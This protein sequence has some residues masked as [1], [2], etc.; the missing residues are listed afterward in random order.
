MAEVTL[1]LPTT[2]TGMRGANTFECLIPAENDELL[3]LESNGLWRPMRISKDPKASTRPVTYAFAQSD[4]K[5]CGLLQDILGNEILYTI[6][7]VVAISFMVQTVAFIFL[8]C[9]SEYVKY[10]YQQI[11][12][13][14]PDVLRA[15][16]QGVSLAEAEKKA[17]K[18]RPKKKPSPHDE[19]D[20]ET[21]GILK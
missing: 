20:P 11:L 3:D 8:C 19:P 4:F 18:K 14:D 6:F 17:N 13:D 12:Q 16:P 5:A 2:S 9:R 7:K 1:S 10:R 15:R 21:F